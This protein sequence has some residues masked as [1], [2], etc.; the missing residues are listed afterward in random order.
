VLLIPVHTPPHKSD[1]EDPGGEHRLAMCR[2]S[3]AGD[4]RLGV[5]MIELD[6]GGPSY[7]VDTL[8]ELHARGPADQLVLI[9]GGDM[10]ATLP[11]WREPAEI[12]RLAQL[13]VAER[14]Q[15]NRSQITESL[16]GLDPGGL[17]DERLAFFAMP[18]FDV[19]SSMV[20]ERVAAGEPIRYLVPHDV[21]RYIQARGLYRDPA[22]PS[23]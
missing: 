20:R 9:L 3:V 7:T 19:S 10:A 5:S 13:G 17:P 21:A 8:R 16:R 2:L 15:A 18:R 12:L 11:G 14:A 22:G 4:E 6:R 1:D 23:L